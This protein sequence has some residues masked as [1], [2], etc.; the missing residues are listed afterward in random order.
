MKESE[1]TKSEASLP[2]VVEVIPVM[3]GLPK[4]ALTYFYRGPVEAGE[5]VNID[6]RGTQTMAL[7]TRVRNAR[8]ARADLRTG[9]FALKKLSGRKENL[10]ISSSL[11]RA[12]EKTAHYYAATT[13]AVLGALISK[14]FLTEPDLL[15]FN[16]PEPE[17]TPREPVIIQLETE[18]RFATY[19]SIIRERFAKKESVLFIAPS[20]E[21]ARRAY[22]SLSQGIEDYTYLFTIAEKKKAAKDAV[23]QARSSAHPILFV[24]TT[25]GLIFDRVDLST[26]ILEGESSNGYRTRMKPYISYKT[27]IEFYAQTSGKEL[28]IGDTVLSIETLWK[29]KQGKFAEFVP[30]KWRVTAPSKTF[31]IDMK[32]NK[33]ESGK[34]EVFSPELKALIHTAL[35]DGDQ[36]FLFGARKGL[37]PTTVCGDCGS[38]LPCQN[39]G[40]PIVLHKKNEFERIYVCHACGDTRSAETKCDNCTSWKLVPL[41]IGIDRIADEARSIWRDTPVFIFDKDHIETLTAARNLV[42]KIRSAGPAIIVGSELFTLYQETIPHAAIVSMDSLFAIPDFGIHERIFSLVT[43]IREMTTHNLIIQTRNI[44]KDVLT[45]ASKG[46]ILGFYRSELSDREAFAYP[47]FSVFIKVSIDLEEREVAREATTL[48][49]LF[50]IWNPDFMKVRS[51]KAGHSIITMIIRLP[52]DEWPE[53]ELLQKLSL[54]GPDFLVKVDPESIL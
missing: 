20:N 54:L 6:V 31:V 37:P 45:Q 14:F 24:T 2:Q 35:T 1:E 46:D 38:L 15:T 51:K 53:K 7:V 13:G 23:K 48:K 5:F 9:S 39:C 30:L 10:G 50:S 27:L 12:A 34:F 25:S 19:K 8:E 41:G 11:A 42:K 4:A 49:Q 33:D 36:I 3:K 28:V 18:E 32:K 43:R 21:L 17:R 52:R 16:I 26:I 29:E 40:A 44:G 22:E 47:P